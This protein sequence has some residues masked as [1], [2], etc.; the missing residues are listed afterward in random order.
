VFKLFRKFLYPTFKKNKRENYCDGECSFYYENF[1]CNKTA[2]KPNS[3]KDFKIQCHLD[4]K[5]NSYVSL[6]KTKNPVDSTSKNNFSKCYF[7]KPLF[8]FPKV[9][10]FIIFFTLSKFQNASDVVF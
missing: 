2:V 3:N 7:V 1:N 4:L 5:M 6:N 8:N 10:I 9:P